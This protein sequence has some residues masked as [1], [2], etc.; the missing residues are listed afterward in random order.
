MFCKMKNVVFLLKIVSL[1]FLRL[2]EYICSFSICPL[3]FNGVA[4]KRQN[5]HNL[6]H[7][8]MYAYSQLFHGPGTQH[9]S[10]STG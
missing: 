9:M 2:F 8:F 4:L 1:L 7:Y 10:L 6:S 3:N 5:I